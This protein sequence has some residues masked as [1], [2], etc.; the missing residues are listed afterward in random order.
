MG[1]VNAEFREADAEAV[2]AESA[3]IDVALVN[4]IFNL[5]PNRNAIFHDLSRVIGRGGVVF[6]AE[7]VLKAPLPTG[8]TSSQSDWF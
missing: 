5:N 3:S 2:P 7:L 4:G 1:L 6:A 8:A